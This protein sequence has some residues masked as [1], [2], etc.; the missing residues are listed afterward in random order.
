MID[1]RQ[2][3]V[4]LAYAL[5]LSTFVVL[6]ACS[7]S[8]TTTTPAIF[9]PEAKTSTATPSATVAAASAT[10]PSV[11]STTG[12]P[13]KLPT[14][15][16][17]PT[18]TAPR[19]GPTG[20]A[21]RAATPD[22]APIR[23]VTAPPRDII[24][25]SAYQ[26]DAAEATIAAIRPDGTGRET[27]SAFPGHPWGP[28]VS[29]DGTLLLFSSAAP[30]TVGRASDLDLNGTGSPDLWIANA[31][32]SQARRL[33]EGSAGY[34]GWSWSPDGRWVAF[35]SNR[36]GSWD[37]YKI[38]A[39][40]MELT[41]LTTSSSQDGWPVWT[42]DGA[43]IVFAATRSD[44]AQLYRMAASGGAVQ[45]LLTS[46]SADTEPTI[47]PDGRLAFSAQNADGTGEIYVLDNGSATARPLTTN[48]GLKSAPSW[49]PDG[50]RLVFTWQRAG[51]SDLYV[52]N[53]DGSGLLGLTATGR[54]QRPD[55][56]RAPV[57]EFA[58]LMQQL[59]ARAESQ[60]RTGALEATYDDKQGT[61]SVTQVQFDLGD[62]STPPR[63]HRTTTSQGPRGTATEEQI[64]I[65]DRAWQQQPD[66][67][68]VTI[69]AP[70]RP[71]EQVTGYFPQIASA[72]QPTADLQ[73]LSV[74]LNWDDPDTGTGMLLTAGIVDGLPIGLQR[75]DRRTGATTTIT[76]DWR[77]PVTITAPATP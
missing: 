70:A 2:S 8:A 49:S 63:I 27:F 53:A 68:W 11:Q 36:G 77:A 15:P 12:L 45:R 67:R 50:R 75:T 38:Q 61:R 28:R 72:Q 71:A 35:A 62:Q 76:Y 29:P 57:D 17:T 43:G 13:P 39:T 59:V 6:S 9:T 51:R 21:T 3:R 1:A 54:N 73:G 10:S 7:S 16:V 20:V 30:A 18:T 47:A 37:I 4:A 52:L 22:A 58:V 19:P 64:V 48:G 66:G 60:R 23:S 14:Q 34:N 44:R 56:G 69:Q 41:R 25:F 31:D 40:G 32:G 33:A 65:G 46:P 5:L 26:A 24:R 55:W 42:P 74:E